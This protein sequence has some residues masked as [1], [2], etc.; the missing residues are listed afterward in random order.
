ME[1]QVKEKAL[2]LQ[3][4]LDEYEKRIEKFRVEI[5]GICD[6]IASQKVIP[7]RYKLFK[8]T[9][10]YF[11]KRTEKNLKEFDYKFAYRQ[12]ETLSILM[13]TYDTLETF[14]YGFYDTM[15]QFYDYNIDELSKIHLLCIM[16][17]DD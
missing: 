11:F 13:T 6:G 2:L 1:T 4:E 10:E 8:D 16:G 17:N 15:K 14:L 12:F 9:L 5:L 7:Q 3:F